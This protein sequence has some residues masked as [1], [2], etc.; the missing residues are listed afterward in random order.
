MP[1][2][3]LIHKTIIFI[4]LLPETLEK[5]EFY[6]YTIREFV[7]FGTGTALKCSRSAYI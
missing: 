7:T 2:F 4:G 5:T 3:F 6:L 1:P